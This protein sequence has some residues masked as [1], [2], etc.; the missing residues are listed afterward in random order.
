[1]RQARIKFPAAEG[2]ATYHCISRTVNGERLFDDADKEMLRRHIWQVADFCGVQI[3]TYCV[4]SN[5]FHI[6]VR[7]PKQ[8]PVPDEELLRRYRV[9][10]PKPSGFQSACLAAIEA[11]LERNGT[12]VEN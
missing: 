8:Q 4:L 6:L 1:M 2:D 12:E 5:H 11:D 9:L 3:I 7:V 10:Y